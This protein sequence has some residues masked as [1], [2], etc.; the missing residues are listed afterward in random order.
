MTGP[1]SLGRC[2]CLYVGGYLGP[3]GRVCRRSGSR[4]LHPRHFAAAI[5]PWVCRRGVPLIGPTSVP[6][7]LGTVRKNSSN[8]GGEGVGVSTSH[9]TLT[10]RIDSSHRF[11]SPT[12]CP[13]R[14]TGTGRTSRTESASYC[15]R[16]VMPRRGSRRSWPAEFETYVAATRTNAPSGGLTLRRRI[17]PAIATG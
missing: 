11:A 17:A 16:T 12:P 7:N 15:C 5:I 8:A 1:H 4:N 3:A 2:E 10:L 6:F 13:S 14:P 9:N